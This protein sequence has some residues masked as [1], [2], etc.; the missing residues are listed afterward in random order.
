[1]P[2][3]TRKV[4]SRIKWVGAGAMEVRL[5]IAHMTQN[6]TFHVE[7]ASGTAAER[8]QARLATVVGN[9]P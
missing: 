4:L 2:L 7:I 3:V 9:A 8:G 5:K 6:A 1:M